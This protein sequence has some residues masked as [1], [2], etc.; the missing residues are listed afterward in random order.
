MQKGTNSQRMESVDVARVVAV[1]AVIAIHTS[2][3]EFKLQTIGEE[4]DLATV[5]NQI[6]RFAVPM[7]SVLAG[8]F[9]ANKFEND[10]C[11]FQSTISLAKR[12]AFL[13]VAWSAIYLLPTNLIDSFAYGALGP[14]KRI[15][16]NLRSAASQPLVTLFEGTKVHLWFLASLLCCIGISAVLIRFNL[17]RSLVILALILYFLGLA[18]KAYSDSP[19]GFQSS[20]NF[21]YGPFFLLIFFITGYFLQRKKTKDSWFSIGC[22]IFVFGFILQF[23]ELHILNT[24]WG[25]SLAQDYVV[26]TF[27][28][29][30]GAAL[31]ALSNTK[32]LHLS[33]IA[34]IGKLVLGIY[35]S[36]Y[37]F[38]DLLSPIDKR[39]AGDILW[40]VAFVCAVFFLSYVTA[41]GCSKYQLT[42][43]LV[44]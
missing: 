32:L 14:I 11:L 23:F 12:I 40:D 27:F 35:A 13:Y 43:K 7:F 17:K 16:W 9:W 29:G 25:V 5:I 33:R 24:K 20:F 10:S 18:G 8:Y 15:Y 30:T 28:L 38:I 1:L 2:P 36:H 21:R 41:L 42:K 44:L 6:S 34:S 3:F 39:Y 4:V 19:F 26:G 22:F 37:I 31:I